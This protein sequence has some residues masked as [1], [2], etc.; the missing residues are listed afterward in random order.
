MK[1]YTIG[2]GGRKTSEFVDLLKKANVTT[3][4]DVRLTPERAFLAI[5][6][7]GKNP[8]K[9]IQGLLGRAGIQ[10]V[11]V[12]ELGNPFKD[13]KDWRPKYQLH[14]EKK[15]DLLCSKLY[16]LKTSFCLLCAEKYASTCHRK[17]ISDYLAD[18]GYEVEH[19]E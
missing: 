16:E 14:L 19:L 15:G 3:V 8:S 17:V 5:Y 18:K 4:V 13:D 2:Y 7:K 12:P 9:G 11:S 10:Y 1:I 6:A